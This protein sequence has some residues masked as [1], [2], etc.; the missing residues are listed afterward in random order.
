[1][2]D[3]LISFDCSDSDD[4][5][6]TYAGSDIYP[7]CGDFSSQVGAAYATVTYLQCT[8]LPTTIVNSVQYT[9]YAYLGIYLIYM[10]VWTVAHKGV[11]ALLFRDT[12][13]SFFNLQTKKEE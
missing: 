1:M 8:N 5:D 11:N 7:T 4:Y 2:C 13:L 12:W 3:P 10:V 9:L 6:F